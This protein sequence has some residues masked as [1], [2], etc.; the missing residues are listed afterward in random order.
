VAQ[1][2]TETT[3]EYEGCAARQEK[4]SGSGEWDAAI[5]YK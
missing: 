1:A 2:L 4:K 3:E 5:A